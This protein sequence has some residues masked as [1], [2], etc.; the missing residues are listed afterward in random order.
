M[1]IKLFC[2]IIWCI[3]SIFTANA[4]EKNGILNVGVGILPGIGGSISYD[5][6]V[7]NLGEYSA[8]SVGGYVGYSRREGYTLAGGGSDVVFWDSKSLL[9]PRITCQYFSEQ[10]KF[11]IFGAFMPGISI[12]RTYR[13]HT[14]FGFFAGITAGFRIK[15]FKNLSVFAEA[16][17]N[18]LCINSGLSFR[19]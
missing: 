19:Y 3:A 15:L 11:E 12:D 14:K 10:Q 5:H 6:K 2:L 9:A 17:Y 4:Q 1:K 16:G 18:V 7:K 8:F 13:E